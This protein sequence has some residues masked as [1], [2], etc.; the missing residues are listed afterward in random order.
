MFNIWKSEITNQ[1]II[2]PTDW[3]PK[4]KDWT[5]IDTVDTYE[6]GERIALS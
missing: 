2:L 5:L 4:G 1:K 6:E 3:L